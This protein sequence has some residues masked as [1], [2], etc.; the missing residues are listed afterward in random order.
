M[1]IKSYR[2]L[3]LAFNPFG[4]LNREERVKLALADVSHWVEWMNKPGHA[5]QLLADHGRGKS[6]HL[7]AL[8]PLL[9]NTPY[10]Q[11]R[12]GEKALWQKSSS[13][14]IDSIENL[15]LWQ[16]WRIYRRY[17]SIAVTSHLDL[18]R[19]MQL[20]GLKVKTLLISTLC[21]D[22]LLQIFNRRLNYARI[23]SRG[24]SQLFSNTS[25]AKGVKSTKTLSFTLPKDAMQSFSSEDNCIGWHI[26]L[27]VD[28]PKWP[29]FSRRRGLLVI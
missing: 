23:V 21:T 11:L 13:Y 18:S 14:C 10:I 19:E 4:E 3:N 17:Q 1:T 5:L 8:Q 22:K 20:A 9:N 24:T 29:D 15:S 6:T 27:D 7:M 2:D 25:L 26:A 16:R 28:I 12:S